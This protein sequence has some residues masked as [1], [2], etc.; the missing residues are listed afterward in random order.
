[1]KQIA[2]QK[3]RQCLSSSLDIDKQQ[4]TTSPSWSINALINEQYENKTMIIRI[5]CSNVAKEVTPVSELTFSRAAI[6][7]TQ[8]RFIQIL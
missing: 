3:I 2:V 7:R 6:E 4:V 8:H 5:T 1:M